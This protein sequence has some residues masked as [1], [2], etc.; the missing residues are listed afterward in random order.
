VVAD[1]ADATGMAVVDGKGDGDESA[2]IM[3]GSGR[4]A[5]ASGRRWSGGG[6]HCCGARAGDGEGARGRAFNGAG[7]GSDR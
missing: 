6:D 3:A 4:S 7:A 1:D 2:G 5:A